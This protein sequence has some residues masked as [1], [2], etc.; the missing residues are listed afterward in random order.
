MEGAMSKKTKK[1]LKK[2]NHQRNIKF[3]NPLLLR[4][5]YQ[6]RKGKDLLKGYIL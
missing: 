2:V 4:E 6:T 5:A 1:P 3:L